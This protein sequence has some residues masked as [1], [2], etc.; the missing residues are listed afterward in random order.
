[1]VKPWLFFLWETLVSDFPI[2]SMA[3]RHFR[4]RWSSETKIL[5]TFVTTTNSYYLQLRLNFF[6][7]PRVHLMIMNNEI[8]AK[9]I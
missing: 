7:Y 4:D 5:K 9:M 8:L 1:M 6:T 3:A 2:G